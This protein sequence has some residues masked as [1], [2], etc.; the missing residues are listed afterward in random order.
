MHRLFIYGS[1]LSSESNHRALRDARC[2]GE[3]RTLP[4]HTLYD[5]GPYPALVRGGSTAVTGELYEVD[6]TLLAELDAFEAVPRLFERATIALADG[7][8]AE[9][10][11]WTHPPK[12]NAIP[13]GDYRL[14]FSSR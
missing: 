2:L 9:T 10:Y 14:R 6:D 1:L 3:A 13:S 8:T 4:E 5:L 11:V 7:T 12:G